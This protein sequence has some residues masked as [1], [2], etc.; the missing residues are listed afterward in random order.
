MSVQDIFII[1]TMSIGVGI[2]FIGSLG[3]IR[4]PDLYM[5]ASAAAKASTLGSAFLLIAFAIHFQ[6]L[7]L[8]LRALA[9]IA[10]LLITTP[11]A[12]HLIGRAAYI[13]GSKLWDESIIDELDGYYDDKIKHPVTTEPNLPD[14]SN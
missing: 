11:I 12:G 1:I 10:F 3:L 2:M 5:R 13:N 4:L 14:K 7:G 6:E 8:S 9:T